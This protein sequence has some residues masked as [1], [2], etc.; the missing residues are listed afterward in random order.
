[1][2]HHCFSLRGQ[3]L[4]PFRSSTVLPALEQNRRAAVDELDKL[5]ADRKSVPINY[6]HYYTETIQ[7]KRQQR[8]E[9]QLGKHVPKNVASERW[10]NAS[11][12]A[13]VSATVASWGKSGQADMEDFS[14]EEALDCL[15]AIYKVNCPCLSLLHRIS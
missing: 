10:T 11:A 5:L 1:M 13:V 4:T 12:E 8:I 3:Y 6:N 7:Q 14:C 9:K 15:V 2:S